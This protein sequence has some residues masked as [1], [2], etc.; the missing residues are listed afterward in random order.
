[1]SNHSFNHRRG[2]VFA[3]DSIGSTSSS[4][5]SGA[6][7]GGNISDAISQYEG[8]FQKDMAD[9]MKLYAEKDKISK[10]TNTMQTIMDAAM[11]ASK[12]VS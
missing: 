8:T 12:A 9:Q 5:S 2:P 10:E 7:G 1:M 11:K 6:S 4:A 3:A